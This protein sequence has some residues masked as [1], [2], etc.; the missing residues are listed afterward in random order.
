LRLPWERLRGLSTRLIEDRGA[1][2]GDSGRQRLTLLMQSAC[3]NPGSK[4]AEGSSILPAGAPGAPERENDDDLHSRAQPG[5]AGRQESR[6]R[7][8]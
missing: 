3:V 6:G 7:F 1:V 8:V 4:T 2:S 5:R